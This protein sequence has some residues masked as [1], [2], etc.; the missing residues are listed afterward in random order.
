[1]HVPCA[2]NQYMKA[3]KKNPLVLGAS[4]PMVYHRGTF[5]RKG[6]ALRSGNRWFLRR[7]VGINQGASARKQFQQKERENRET[8]SSG[9]CQEEERERGRGWRVRVDRVTREKGRCAGEP[10]RS[11]RSADE[12]QRA[13]EGGRRLCKRQPIRLKCTANNRSF[14]PFD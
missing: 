5:Y 3:N 9:V 7:A 14:N 13:R 2:I 8:F 6:S 4:L 1:M 12:C 11:C 10:K